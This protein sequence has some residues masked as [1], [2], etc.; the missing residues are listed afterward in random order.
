MTLAELQNLQSMDET[1]F[2]DLWVIE[3]ING[4]LGKDAFLE[5][6][7]SRLPDPT[8]EGEISLE[9]SMT[10]LGDL[11]ESPVMHLINSD[12]HGNCCHLLEVLCN[13]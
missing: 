2:E 3:Q 5:E 10:A 12:L 6:I 11:A 1:V 9:D 7:I 4:D 8:P 13:D